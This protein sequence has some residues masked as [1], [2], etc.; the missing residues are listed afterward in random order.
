MCGSRQAVPT[1]LRAAFQSCGQNCAGAE[2]FIVHSAVYDT[3]VARVA[4]VAARMRQGSPLG[5]STV[6]A[7]AMC[8]PGL[9]HKVR[10]LVDDA[11]AHGAKVLSHACVSL[12]MGWTCLSL[13]S[14]RPRPQWDHSAAWSPCICKLLCAHLIMLNGTAVSVGWGKALARSCSRWVGSLLRCGHSCRYY[15]GCLTGRTFCAAQVLA[16]GSVVHPVGGERGQYYPPTVLTGV[17]PA[18]RI[19]QEE[20]FGPVLAVAPFRSDDEAVRLANDCCFGLGSAVFSRSQAHARAL[21]SRLEVCPPTPSP[22]PRP[23]PPW[24]GG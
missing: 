2:R 15:A 1:A 3:F 7:G 5:G 17:T 6:D 24:P 10:E 21:A 16:G 13:C 22:P 8:L 20:V 4:D 9:A 23:Y 11:V 19:W 14:G 18:M 12:C